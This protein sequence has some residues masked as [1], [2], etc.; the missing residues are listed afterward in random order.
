MSHRTLG[1][2]VAVSR[3]IRAASFQPGAPI[4]E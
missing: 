1:A 3:A 2:I 4:S